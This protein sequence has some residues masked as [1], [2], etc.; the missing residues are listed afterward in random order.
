M[1][2]N[3]DGA[4]FEDLNATGIGVVVCDSHG[5]VLATLVEIIP[6]P[7]SIHV[8]ETLAARRAIHFVQEL[9]MHSSVFEGDSEV[10]IST[11]KNQ[12]LSHPSCGHLDKDILS[13]ASSFQ[14]F[15]FSHTFQQSNTLA[16]G[17]LDIF[18]VYV[19]DCLPVK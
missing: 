18:K 1:K 12:C 7:S 13:S 8:L 3:F 9:G 17:P 11:K 6:L 10:S 4:V 14:N 16:Y 19:S 15:S 2:T 5:E